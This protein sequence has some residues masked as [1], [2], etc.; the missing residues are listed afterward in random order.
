MTARPDLLEQRVESRPLHA[1]S[2][3]SLNVLEIASLLVV[4]VDEA[5]ELTELELDRGSDPVFVGYVR[6]GL[7]DLLAVID[8]ALVIVGKVEDEEVSKIERRV[9]VFIPSIV[10]VQILASRERF[11]RVPG[12]VIDTDAAPLSGRTVCGRDHEHGLEATFDV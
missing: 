9:H 7:N 3:K 8:A 5:V 10:F 4:R 12:T 1:C 11:G 6:D 2:L